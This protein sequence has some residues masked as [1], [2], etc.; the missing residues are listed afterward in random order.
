M[1]GWFAVYGYTASIYTQQGVIIGNMFTYFGISSVCRGAPILHFKW[2][3]ALGYQQ[4]FPQNMV[5]I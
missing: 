2:T 3:I 1:A 4:H 5:L